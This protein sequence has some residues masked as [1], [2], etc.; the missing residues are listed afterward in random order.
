[1]RARRL[2]LELRM[3]LHG[4]IPRMPWQFGDFDELAVRRA[5]GNLQTTLGQ[6]AFVEAIEFV[7]MAMPFLDEIRA[8]DALR[9]R[10]GRQ[11]TRIAAEPHRA[12]E[13]VDAEQ[14]AQLVD[15]LGGGVRIALGG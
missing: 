15:H 11:R 7:A 14:I 10:T 6:S 9:E 2:R 4:D 3:E 5:A 1:M 8:V 12:A 13:I